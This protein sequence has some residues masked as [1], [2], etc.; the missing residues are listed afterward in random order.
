M[1]LL[2]CVRSFFKSILQRSRMESDMDEEF[3][4][5]R[6]SYIGDL[7]RAG[8]SSK[9]AERR[10]CL[11]FGNPE[12]HKENC[13]DSLGLRLWNELRSDLHYAMRGLR[14][15][16]GFTAVA[17]ISLALGI[18][19]NTA[20]FSLAEDNCDFCLGRKCRTAPSTTFGEMFQASALRFLI[21]SSRICNNRI[22]FFNPSSP[23]KTFMA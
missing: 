10:A 19:A 18:G 21:P 3:R 17:V 15:S 6:E 5:H 9:E 16:P 12:L 14:Q 13:R 1:R 2:A 8:L 23:S 22:T 4:F 11:E 20:I 7:L